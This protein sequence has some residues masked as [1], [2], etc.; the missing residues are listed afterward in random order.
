MKHISDSL[1]SEIEKLIPKKN[2]KVGRPEF[3]NKKVFEGVIFVL[4]TNTQWCELPEKYGVYTTVHGK[5]MKWARAGVFDKMMV[6]ARE[7]YRRRNSKNIWYAIDTL[8]K[9]APFAKFGG[10]NP[11][12]RGKRGIK[13]SLIVD[14]RGAPLFVDVA[15]ANKNDSGIF[16]KTVSKMRKSKQI[17][18]MAAD[19][20]FDVKDLR[21]YAKGKNIALIAAPNKRRDKTKHKFNV[22][23]RW[24]VEQTFGILAWFRGLKVCWAKTLISARSALQ[25]ACSLRIFKMC[26]IF[27]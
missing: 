9:K 11:T 13:Q 22:P 7:Y 8:I 6:K 23:H 2:K 21:S 20:A 10:K 5:Y 18:I 1:W 17:R 27:G 16:K 26:G 3:D 4:R 14:R 19:S 12:D 24:I 15:P 25:I